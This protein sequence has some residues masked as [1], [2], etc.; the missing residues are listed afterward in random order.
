MHDR[1][2]GAHGCWLGLARGG[3]QQR[4]HDQGYSQTRGWEH[5]STQTARCTARVAFC[6][7][8]AE[9]PH[10][11]GR[12]GR[13]QLRARPVSSMQPCMHGHG[14]CNRGGGGSCMATRSAHAGPPPSPADERRPP[15]MQASQGP[16][17]QHQNGHQ[18]A[19]GTAAPGGGGG[20]VGHS[21]GPQS[22]L[23]RRPAC[24]CSNLD[25]RRALAETMRRQTPVLR[26]NEEGASATLLA[27][28][29]PMRAGVVA[30]GTGKAGC[31]PGVQQSAPACVDS[32][33]RAP[34]KQ[35]QLR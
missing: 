29:V 12:P 14:L 20:G 35:W 2:H 19:A 6:T 32:V 8:L 28:G 7:A 17:E 16:T 23:G 30:L 1:G 18:G 21:R 15:S 4:E 33:R 25:E 27:C 13:P 26:V 10:V 9:W 34:S 3:A 31:V 22:L 24:Q 5:S 11:R